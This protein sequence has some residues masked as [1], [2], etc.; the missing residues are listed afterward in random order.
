M[1]DRHL[2]RFE[3]AAEPQL[4]TRGDGLADLAVYTDVLANYGSDDVARVTGLVSGPLVSD[5]LGLLVS[6]GWDEYG[7]EWNNNLQ[8]DTA[9][10]SLTPLPGI[11]SP[12]V[13]PPQ[14]GDFAGYGEE[15]AR[16]EE[17]LQ[18]LAELTDLGG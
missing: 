2:R 7:G 11:Q 1:A 12:W 10:T 13:D 17:I 4:S 14:E 15:I 18:R 9:D 8:P 6:V 5:R 16:L 3:R